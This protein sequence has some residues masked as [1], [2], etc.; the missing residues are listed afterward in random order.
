MTDQSAGA[1][2]IVFLVMPQAIAMVLVAG[3]LIQMVRHLG[4]EELK[5]EKFAIGVEKHRYGE[6][7]ISKEQRPDYPDPPPQS[8]VANLDAERLGLEKQGLTH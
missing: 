1:A 8:F 6:G 4:H 7:G 2:G 3:L 5:C